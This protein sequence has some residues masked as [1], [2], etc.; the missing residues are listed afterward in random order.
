[1]ARAAIKASDLK[2]DRAQKKQDH[3]K[4]VQQRADRDVARAAFQA[5]T[6]SGLTPADKDDLL[7]LMA[8]MLGVIK[9]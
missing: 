2:P 9:E 7:K 8:Q 1:M 6:W 3:D 4:D 5:K